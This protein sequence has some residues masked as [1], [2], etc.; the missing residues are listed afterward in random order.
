MFDLNAVRAV[1]ARILALRGQGAEVVEW[2]DWLEASSR[3]LGTP[4]DIVL[5]LASAAM[6]RA[7]VGQ[8]EAAAALLAELES[9]PGSRDNQSYPALLPAMVRTALGIDHPELAE[10]LVS[11]L[12][13]RTPYAE[14][15]LVAANAALTEARGDLSSAADAYA[16]AA[17]RWERFG[18]VPEQ[19]F[20]L[21]G[22][23]RCLVGLSRPTE[24]APVLRHAREIFERLRAAPALAETDALLQQTT[25]LSS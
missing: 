20:A 7:G 23:G 8:D 10:R 17:D 16:D 15:A 24:A 13:P 12:E 14:H 3:E 21:L 19:A 25:A 18:V 1:Q 5:G 22:Q 6:G 4:E 2:L 11:G 9:Y